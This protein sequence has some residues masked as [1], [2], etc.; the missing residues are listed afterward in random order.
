VND[1]VSYFDGLG[2]FAGA[3][4]FRNSIYMRQYIGKP[5]FSVAKNSEIRYTIRYS[6]SLLAKVVF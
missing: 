4:A 3:V 6:G 1:S 5:L 2:K